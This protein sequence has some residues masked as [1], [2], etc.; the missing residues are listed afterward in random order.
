[1]FIND[2]GNTKPAQGGLNNSKS[3]FVL[4]GLK[5]EEKLVKDTLRVILHTILFQRELGVVVPRTVE[6][7]SGIHYLT[8]NDINT[9][10]IVEEN[11][12]AV[13]SRIRE[14]NGGTVVLGF[15]QVIKKKSFL[16][17]HDNSKQV[18][19]EWRIPLRVVQGEGKKPDGR[20]VK[21]LR[22]VL[23]QVIEWICLKK[24]HLP[25]MGLPDDPSVIRYPFEISYAGDMGDMY[26]VQ[27]NSG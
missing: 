2:K 17:F 19:E 22:K 15:Y 18:W 26:F 7:D 16:L 3:N 6:S 13:C 5:V 12:S 1:M 25:P 24:D 14:M 4:K 21:R 9:D 11:L 8:L 27:K 20:F 23:F 10:K